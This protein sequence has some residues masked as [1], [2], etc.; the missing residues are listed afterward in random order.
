MPRKQHPMTPFVAVVRRRKR[1]G[2]VRRT[3]VSPRKAAY[4][5]YIR[6]PAWRAF[7]TA[8]WAEY[9]K[10]NKVRTCYCCGRAQSELNSPLELHHRT[11]ERMGSEEWTDIVPICKTDH[12]WVTRHWRNRARTKLTMTLWELTDARRQMV[13]GYTE[14][15]RGPAGGY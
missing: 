15:K 12:A 11:Y 8:W 7:R 3:S 4:L 10:K 9:D 1:R 13:R 5:A 6:S 14:K 2:S